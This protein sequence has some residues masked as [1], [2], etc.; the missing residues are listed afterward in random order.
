MNNSVDRIRIFLQDF[1]PR[2]GVDPRQSDP[3]D[4]ISQ[5]KWAMDELGITGV[6]FDIAG[7]IYRHYHAINVKKE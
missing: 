3:I 7:E 5:V 6:A 4:L 1:L 2:Q